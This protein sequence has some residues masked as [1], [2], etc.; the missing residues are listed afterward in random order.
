MG[1]NAVGYGLNGPSREMLYVKTSRDIK[2]KAKSWSDMY[3]NFIQKSIGSL[4]NLYFNR[5]EDD[6][7][8]ECFNRSF[9][10]AFSCGWVVIWAAAA[11]RVG[12]SHAELVKSGKV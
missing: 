1:V 6:C 9:T 12:L 5:E 8:P 11:L 3:G 7:K 4:V 2:Y 10:G